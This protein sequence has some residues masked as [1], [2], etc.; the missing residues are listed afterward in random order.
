MQS[1]T[2]AKLQ[3][4]AT[5]HASALIADNI[6]DACRLAVGRDAGATIK[7]TVKITNPQGV[8][9]VATDASV[10]STDKLKSDPMEETFNPNQPELG[11]EGA[12]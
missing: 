7:V 5:A 4:I 2:I 8:W 11:M 10:S 6:T 9:H 1:E 3:E 12:K